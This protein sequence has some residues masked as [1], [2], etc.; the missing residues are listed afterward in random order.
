MTATAQQ[1]E[2]QNSI[3]SIQDYPKL[4]ILFRDVTSYWK[5]RKAYA[6]SIELLLERYKMRVSPKWSAPKRVAS[7]FGAGCAWLG[8]GFVQYVK[9]RKL[10]RETIAETYE[11]EYAP[12]SWKSMSTRLNRRQRAFGRGRFWRLAHHWRHREA[13]SVVWAGKPTGCGVHH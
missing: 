6:L 11:L 8:V 12:I 10:P 3:K 1:L 4:S 5:T 7:L 13:G 9:P 2:F